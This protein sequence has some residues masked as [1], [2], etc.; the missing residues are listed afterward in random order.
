MVS[1]PSGTPEPP[2]NL[3]PRHDVP[4]GGRSG[5][6]ML[7]PRQVH[8]LEWG[9]ARLP[10]V[11]CLHGGGQ[12]AYMFEQLGAALAGR[13]H[14]L[15]WDF[16]DHGDSDPFPGG[17]AEM[18][19]DRHALA[20][21]AGPLCTEFGISRAVFVGGSMGG[22]V[23]VT[24]AA[25]WPDLVGGVVLL[26][27]GHRLE[28]AGVQRIA[29]FLAEHESF[30]DLD[31]AAAAIAGYLPNRAISTGRLTRNLRQRAD[32]RWVWKHNLGSRLRARRDAEVDFDF[33]EG[34]ATVVAGLDDDLRRLTRPALVLRG[35]GSDVLS[36]AGADEL[37]ALL[38]D[39]R[40]ARITGAGHLAAGD[41]PE[42]FVGHVIR[43]LDEISWG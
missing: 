38:P 32:G 10:A 5:F 14:V 28:A 40:Y 8:Y 39:A 25:R 27:V 2:A 24:V 30:A 21:D 22:L 17:P 41:N 37:M 36:E 42:S 9:H 33:D 4:A 35:A 43:F 23:A 7:G 26:D 18:P 16:A 6:V 15:A 12:T 11:V 3:P 13:F 19:L 20:A 29:A 34:A 1:Q 31:E